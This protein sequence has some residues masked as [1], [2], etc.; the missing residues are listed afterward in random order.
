MFRAGLVAVLLAALGGGAWYFLTRDPGFHY[1]YATARTENAV[2]GYEFSYPPSWQLT[3]DGS[4]SK[5]TAPDGS[6][7]VSLGRG[8]AGDM[9]AASARLVA[10]I[11]G[12]YRR[13]KLGARQ[14][15]LVGG[16]PALTVSGTGR[17][18]AGVSLR[19]LAI[20]IE[21]TDGTTFAI[22]AFT[23]ADADP[24]EVVPRISEV[25]D[26]FRIA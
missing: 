3:T 13:V 20:T 21:G 22:T 5:L 11:Q 25:V 7:V 23:V 6:V 19:F 14:S 26:S 4:T 17:N 16:A 10:Q 8:P 2:G 12:E 18:D 9:S 15:Q 1:R 24:K